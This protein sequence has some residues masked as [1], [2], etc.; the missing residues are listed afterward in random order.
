MGQRANSWSPPGVS[1]VTPG[2]TLRPIQ[3]R[4]LAEFERELIRARTA[5]GRALP[6]KAGQSLGRPFK[7][8]P[9]PAGRSTEAK[10]RRGLG[11][12]NCPHIQ[13]QREY[14]QPA[15]NHA[16]FPNGLNTRCPGETPPLASLRFWPY[17]T[18]FPSICFGEGATPAAARASAIIVANSNAIWSSVICSH[19]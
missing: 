6:K 12:R 5:E 8:T 2:P 1:P 18:L 10:G 7:L 19:L 17:Y 15:L 9:P 13:C 14:D 11:S 4:C 3:R 16:E